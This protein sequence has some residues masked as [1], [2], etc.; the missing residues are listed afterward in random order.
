VR[1]LISIRRAEDH[2]TPPLDAD[3]VAKRLFDGALPP[4][5]AYGERPSDTPDPGLERP[6]AHFRH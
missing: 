3:A 2:A 1:A 5:G 6:L 4:F